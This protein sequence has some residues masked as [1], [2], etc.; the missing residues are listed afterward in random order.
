[1]SK[2]KKN[3]K[4]RRYTIKQ[5]DKMKSKSKTDLTKFDT[6]T[7]ET[8][9]YSDIPDFK[10]EFWA[11]ATVVDHTKKPISLRV[12]NDVLEWFKHQKGRYQKLIN[13]VLRQYMNAHSHHKPAK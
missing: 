8:I 11:N 5:L 6:L 2:T 10:D 9:D 12:D 7:D 13:Q 1:M 4:T 3:S